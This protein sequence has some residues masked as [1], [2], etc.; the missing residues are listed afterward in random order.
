[1]SNT[2]QRVPLAEHFL[3]L[4]DRWLCVRRPGGPNHVQ[5]RGVA[6][7]R[8]IG[9]NKKMPPWQLIHM[10]HTSYDGYAPSGSPR[11]PDI[12]HRSSSS[13]RSQVIR[14]RLFH[15]CMQLMP[16]VAS[17]V[18]L[19]K[20]WPSCCV[21]LKHCWKHWRNGPNKELVLRKFWT[22]GRL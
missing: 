7:Q 5:G 3:R 13:T 11:R 19:S 21:L 4:V 16:I 1:M 2:R 18:K 6:V 8:E 9:R 15:C 22:S 14:A 12:M 10:E 17:L 20:S